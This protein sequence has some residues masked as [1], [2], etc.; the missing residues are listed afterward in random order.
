[1]SRFITRGTQA[2]SRSTAQRFS[3]GS[4]PVVGQSGMIVPSCPFLFPVRGTTVRI[5]VGTAGFEPVTP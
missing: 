2:L 5:M 3:A 4:Q 1:M